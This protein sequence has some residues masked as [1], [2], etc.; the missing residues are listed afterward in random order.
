MTPR[1]SIGNEVW[2]FD[3]MTPHQPSHTCI[4]LLFVIPIMKRCLE[5]K[6]LVFISFSRFFLYDLLLWLANTRSWAEGVTV[7]GFQVTPPPRSS[8]SFDRRSGKRRGR[9]TLIVHSRVLSMPGG[10]GV[11]QS[12]RSGALS[13]FVGNCVDVYGF[14]RRGWWCWHVVARCGLCAKVV[15]GRLFQPQFRRRKDKW[16]DMAHSV[17]YM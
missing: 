13:F 9:K 14:T 8:T 5:W 12:D 7:V 6:L 2:V 3:V 11:W 4:Q 10:G 1:K 16:C 15:L 17:V